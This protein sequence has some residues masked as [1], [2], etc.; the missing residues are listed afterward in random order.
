MKKLLF[1]LLFFPILAFADPLTI[2]FNNSLPVSKSSDSYNKPGC[3]TSTQGYIFDVTMLGWN[4][5]TSTCT[6]T[7]LFSNPGYLTTGQY[8]PR[9]RGQFW[10][11]H[12]AGATF[13]LLGFKIK[14]YGT[15]NTLYLDTTDSAGITTTTVLPPSVTVVGFDPVTFPALTAVS[16]RSTNNRFDITNIIVQ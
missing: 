3:E 9:S 7:N 5:S 16:I 10:M 11:A 15:T 14:N 4:L 12:S 8:A 2:T 6:A 13:A 1:A